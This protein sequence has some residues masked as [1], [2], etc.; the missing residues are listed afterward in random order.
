MPLKERLVDGHAFDADAALIA[1][2]FDQPVDQQERVAMGKELHD[3]RN[4]SAAEFLF[5]LLRL[6][7][8]LVRTTLSV[9]HLPL[10]PRGA[11]GVPAASRPRSAAPTRPSAPPACRPVGR[12]P[13]P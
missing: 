3:A 7:H 11:A 4:V 12:Q 9:P 2:H 8:D 10:A 5:R 1:I 6:F 13:G